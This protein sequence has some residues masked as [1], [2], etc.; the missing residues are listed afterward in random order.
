MSK[1]QFKES[2]NIQNN[3]IDIN[4]Y[5]SAQPLEISENFK[6]SNNN[7][8]ILPNN[9]SF[10]QNEIEKININ[11]IL[12]FDISP[13]KKNSLQ[14]RKDYKEDN[15]Y[16][17]DSIDAN[18][19]IYNNNADS[20]KN[21]K[22]LEKNEDKKRGRAMDRIVK[23]RARL[24]ENNKNKKDIKSSNIMERAKLIEK[25]MGS[26]N[27]NNDKSENINNIYNINNNNLNS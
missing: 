20:F 25:V 12:D 2:T 14:I 7:F 15:N 6:E 16:N 23:G 5:Y 13:Q 9:N 27:N 21:E 24:N 19:N 4:N 11:D 22:Y 8:N 18:D 1:S 10:N 17:L 26:H 3:Y